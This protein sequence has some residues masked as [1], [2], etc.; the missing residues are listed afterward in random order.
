M[1]F[2]SLLVDNLCSRTLKYLFLVSLG[3]FSLLSLYAKDS[4]AIKEAEA[5]FIKGSVS[6]SIEL[7]ESLDLDSN[8]QAL[9]MLASIYCNSEKW[10]KLN[11]LINNMEDIPYLKD[12]S[13]YFSGRIAPVSYTHLTLPTIA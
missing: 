1:I 12:L 5:L 3:I 4:S 13:Y 11:R 7:L 9:I 10:Q 6:A 8:P 2:M